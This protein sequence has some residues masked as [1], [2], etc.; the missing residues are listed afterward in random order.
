M[1]INYETHLVGFVDVMGFKELLVDNDSNRKKIGSY[2]EYIHT[3]QE[4]EKILGKNDLQIMAVSDSVVYAVKLPEEK[5][6]HLEITASFLRTLAILQYNLAVK[7]CIWTRGGVSIG[8]LQMDADKN[9][10]VGQA[11]VD[12]LN[13]EEAANYPRIIIDPKLFKHFQC[14]P[15]DF[16]AKMRNDFGTPILDFKY[17]SPISLSPWPNDYVQLDWFGWG[18]DRSISAEEEALKRISGSEGTDLEM[19]EFFN[20][21]P[22]RQSQN[23]S[24]FLKTQLLL[25]YLQQARYQYHVRGGDAKKAHVVSLTKKL[26]DLTGI[27]LTKPPDVLTV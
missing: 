14:T 9:F 3:N 21:L 20:E 11:F 26:T 15:H 17:D 27:D 19:V 6:K 25:R 13:L 2:F 18:L 12:A 5:S 23:T 16:S 24:L 10:I 7:L 1:E 8:K 4:L 22:Q